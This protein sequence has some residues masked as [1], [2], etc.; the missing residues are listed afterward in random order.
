MD[1]AS[2]KRL[3]EENA[4]EINRLKARIDETVRHR[5]RSK[6]EHDEWS[7]A[8]SEFHARYDNL[9]FPGGYDR[10]RLKID[11]GDF[12]AIEAALCVLE[13]RPYFFRS[14]YMFKDLLRRT[15]RARLSPEQ[16][17]RM[18]VILANYAEFRASKGKK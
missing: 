11:E 18:D 16:R 2:I 9:A 5:S 3:I 12:E 14:G 10:S 4:A 13:V 7:A 15:K 17:A 6:R 8:C 1:A